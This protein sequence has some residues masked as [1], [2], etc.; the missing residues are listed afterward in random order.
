M[1]ASPSPPLHPDR[2]EFSESAGDRGAEGLQSVDGAHEERN[3][4][5][6]GTSNGVNGEVKEVA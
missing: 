2:D 6:N 3:G 1:V 4:V 5:S